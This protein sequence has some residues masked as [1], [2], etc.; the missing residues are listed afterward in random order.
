MCTFVLYTKMHICDRLV[1]SDFFFS[2]SKK[3]GASV[4]YSDIPVGVLMLYGCNWMI[5]LCPVLSHA[6]YCVCILFINSSNNVELFILW[7]SGYQ[8]FRWCFPLFVNEKKQIL[9]MQ[10][11]WAA[12]NGSDFRH[13]IICSC[14]IFLSLS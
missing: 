3:L 7:I 2:P 4:Q 1:F 9:Y 10:S 5:L 6:Y 13:I 11:S 12:H 14:F 8:L